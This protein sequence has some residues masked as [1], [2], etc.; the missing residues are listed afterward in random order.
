MV[1]SLGLYP[2]AAETWGV[3]LGLIITDN[4]Y[5]LLY[6]QGVKYFIRILLTVGQ[7]LRA[8]ERSRVVCVVVVPPCPGA[9]PSG[10]SPASSQ[11]PENDAAPRGACALPLCGQER[12]GQQGLF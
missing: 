7:R 10:R 12:R 5:H 8:E 4:K 6:F 3:P 2:L 11:L 9:L 1:V